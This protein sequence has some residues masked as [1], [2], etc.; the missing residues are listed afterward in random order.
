MLASHD[1]F[2]YQKSKNILLNL[3]S[4]FWKCQKKDINEQYKLGVRIFDIRVYRSKD[5]WGTAHGCVCFNQ[6]FKTI[7]SICKYFNDNFEGSI[8]RIYLEDNVKN[9]NKLRDLFLQEADE[10]FS[11]YKDMLWEIGTHFPWITYYRNK[12]F[13]PEIKEYYCHLFNWNT[14]QSIK[15]NIEHFDKSSWSIPLYAKKHNPNITQEMIEDP[16]IMYMMDYIGIYPK[17]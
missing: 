15:Y 10:A 1:S 6:S 7:S 2:T 14:D 5:K 9:N 8:I 12:D 17:Q 3:F 13:H 11:K 4:I 16:N